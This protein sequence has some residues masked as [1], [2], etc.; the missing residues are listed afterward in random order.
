MI[1]SNSLWLILEGWQIAIRITQP[2]IIM[3]CQTS[4][5]SVSLEEVIFTAQVGSVLQLSTLETLSTSFNPQE[6]GYWKS[7][8]QMCLQYRKT[9]TTDYYT[10]F[11]IHHVSLLHFSR[12]ISVPQHGSGIGHN[13]QIVHTS[14]GLGE[15]VGVHQQG[16]SCGCCSVAAG[17]GLI[18]LLWKAQTLGVTLSELLGCLLQTP[19]EVWPYTVIL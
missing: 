5:S 11:Q 15:A 6:C 14:Q 1:L 13:P 9:Y 12:G 16:V 18:L 3:K 2:L 10:R 17:R 4:F 7:W 19:R 8:T